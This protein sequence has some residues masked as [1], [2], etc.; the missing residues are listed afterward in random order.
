[1]L[2]LCLATIVGSRHNML[3]PNFRQDGVCNAENCSHFHPNLICELCG[4][5]ARRQEYF[6]SHMKGAKHAAMLRARASQNV[7]KRCTICD[8][9]LES[10]TACRDHERGKQHVR[11][12]SELR[13]Q[14]R[15]LDERVILVDDERNMFEC[16][17]CEIQ[18]WQ[19]TKAK[20]EQTQRHKRK[21]RFLSI[22]HALEEAEKDKHG[23]SVSP[24]GKDAFDFGLNETNQASLEFSLKI[25][26]ARL[27]I[28]LRSATLASAARNHSK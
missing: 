7:P 16:S 26:E 12:L 8:V 4:V 10:P 21:E 17:V 14:G 25:D 23:V 15:Q 3:C 11:L 20:H 13:A 2:L 28:V 18:V 1:M 9:R 24:P 5:A 6:D 22:R 19:Q 27:R